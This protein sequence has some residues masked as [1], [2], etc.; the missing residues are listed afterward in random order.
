M[1]VAKKNEFVEELDVDNI[2]ELMQLDI[3]KWDKIDAKVN[4]IGNDIGHRNGAAYN[5]K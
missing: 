4:A 1:V 3:S 2:K 5:Y